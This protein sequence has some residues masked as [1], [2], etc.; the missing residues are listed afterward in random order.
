MHWLGS[1]VKSR[2]LHTHN[3]CTHIARRHLPPYYS[4]VTPREQTT[5]TN[6]VVYHEVRTPYLNCN[7]QTFRMPQKSSGT[8]GAGAERRMRSSPRTRTLQCQHKRKACALTTYNRQHLRRGYID[9][10]HK[11]HGLATFTFLST[12]R[13]AFHD[14]T[15]L[16]NKCR[17]IKGRYWQLSLSHQLRNASCGKGTFRDQTGQGLGNT[18]FYCYNI[19]KPFRFRELN[20]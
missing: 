6:H 4:D 9:R 14:G 7:S 18:V 2:I 20:E 5:L 8:C 12:E 16:R 11:D 13:R 10:Y 15:V 1:S 17:I 3:G 19:G